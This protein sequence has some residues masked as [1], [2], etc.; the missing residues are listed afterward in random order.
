[1]RIPRMEET[2][3]GHRQGVHVGIALQ[4]KGKA[5]VWC[6]VFLQKELGVETGGR[7]STFVIRR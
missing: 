3:R 2:R 6:L 1:M 5:A 7:V 4:S